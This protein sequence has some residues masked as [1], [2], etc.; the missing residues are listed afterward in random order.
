MSR[1]I[2]PDNED[3]VRAIRSSDWD[4]KH[5]RWSSNL[6]KGPNTSVSRLT[7]L[8]L[9]SIF[10]IFFFEL[11]KPPVH[12][13]IK[14]GEIR[15]EKLKKLGNNFVVNGKPQ[16]TTITVEADPIIGQSGIPDNPAHAEI[17]QKLPRSLALEI[18]KQLQFHN[19]P[20]RPIV[21]WIAA[22]IILTALITCL[23]V[24]F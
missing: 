4:E 5:N 13:V 3:I 1:K 16:I 9:N 11:H 14:A 22:L 18:I 21:K 8:P 19:P 17:P 24:L 2:C 15:I 12:K 7:I 20:I 23:M 6:F 10:K